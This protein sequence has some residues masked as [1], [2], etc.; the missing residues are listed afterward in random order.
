MQAKRV[1]T[2]D[3]VCTNIPQEFR[4]FTLTE[5]DS[6]PNKYTLS[7]GNYKSIIGYTDHFEI[8]FVETLPQHGGEVVIAL[9]QLGS[10][11]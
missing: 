5:D 9:S 11:A 10:N 7:F 2:V 8:S 6:G 3:S 1:S 4:T